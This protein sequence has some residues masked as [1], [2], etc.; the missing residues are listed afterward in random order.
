M[1][2]ESLLKDWKKI[3][4]SFPVA[5]NNF[6]G[7][8]LIQWSDTLKKL[9]YLTRQGHKG[10]VTVIT[11]GVIT[12]SMA[13]RFRSFIRRGLKL[14]VCVS[15]SELPQFEK[16]GMEHRYKN[17]SVLNNAGIRNL[18]FVRPM[19]PPYNTDSQTIN[20]IVDN[21]ALNGCQ[22][23]VLSG[24]RGDDNLV[25]D[26]TPSDKVKWTMRVKLLTGTQPFP[27]CLRSYSCG[28]YCCPVFP[29]AQPFVCYQPLPVASFAVITL[30]GS[31]AS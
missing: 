30:T 19:T 27:S 5:V 28:K 17:F 18:A 26:M 14:L 13:E 9:E 11:K 20:R 4:A 29:A 15:I 21:L 31:S 7:D 6:Y 22:N 3:F 23:I 24:F 2:N 16:V 10:V 12:N 8:P 25:K 1:N